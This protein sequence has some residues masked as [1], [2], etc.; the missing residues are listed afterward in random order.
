MV[1]PVSVKPDTRADDRP[2]RD[3]TA[4]ETDNVRD[5]FV[6]CMPPGAERDEQAGRED[7]TGDVD[8]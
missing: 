8:E 5:R 1:L 6:G 4:D 7:S 3:D 2:T